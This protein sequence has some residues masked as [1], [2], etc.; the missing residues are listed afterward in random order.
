MVGMFLTGWRW[1]G[2]IQVRVV[3][4]AGDSEMWPFL[5]S[6]AW[7]DYYSEPFLYWIGTGH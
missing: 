5:D 3:G 7:C 2:R 4:G 6:E 1:G